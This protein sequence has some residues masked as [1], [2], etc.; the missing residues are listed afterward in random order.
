MKIGLALSGGGA[1]GIAH[2]GVLKALEELGVEVHEISGTS[3]GAIAAAFYAHNYTP[4][5]AMKHV[6]STNLFKIV[7]PAFSWRGLFNI[8]KAE[9]VFRKY[10]EE[11]SFDNAR[12]PFK[13]IATNLNTGEGEVFSEGQLVKPMM[14]SCCLPFIFDP[15]DINGSLYVDGGIVNNLPAEVLKETCDVVIG[16]N[17]VPIIKENDLSGMKKMIERISMVAISANVNKSRKQCD[18]LIEPKELRSFGTFDLKQAKKIFDIG[19]EATHHIFEMD[20]DLEVV[21]KV[22]GL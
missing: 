21:K 16:V 22:K 5:E 19:Y 8:S 13:V 15:V 10:F 14:A 18:I 20:K 2:F 6:A 1:R 11:D 7:W 4:E 12:L 9:E 3:A 17:V